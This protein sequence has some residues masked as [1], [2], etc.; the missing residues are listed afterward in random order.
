MVLE[1]VLRRSYELTRYRRP[2]IGLEMGGFCHWLHEQGYSRSVLRSHIAKVSHF[3]QYLR[4]LG[5]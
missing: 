4:Y 1:D 5:G 3:N 2:P